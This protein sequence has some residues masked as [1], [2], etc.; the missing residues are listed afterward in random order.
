MTPDE[1]P[2]VGIRP[3]HEGQRAIFTGRDDD[4]TR[5][6]NK[7][8]SARI[9]VLY[10]PSGVGKTSV[11]RALVVPE[12]RESGAYVVY[13]DSWATDDWMAPLRRSL[14]KS[15]E[16]A[17]GVVAEDA[18]LASTIDGA[19]PG[20]SVVLI[21]DQLEFLLLR[22]P[23][24]VDT[25]RAELAAI[26]ACESD[27]RILLSLR[28]EYLAALDPF[29]TT[30]LSILQSTMR[31]QALDG[32]AAERALIEP[33]E[34]FGRSIDPDLVKRIRSDLEK[35]D[36]SRS[37]R[38]SIELTTLQVIGKVLWDDALESKAMRLTLDAYERL[39][40]RDG[41]CNKFI[42]SA[43]GSLSIIDRLQAAM[44]LE[45]LA[46]PD[47]LKMTFEK[48]RLRKHAKVSRRRLERILSS[49]ESNFVVR[50]RRT[51]HHTY[52]ELQ[53]DALGKML[54]A[55]IS[56]RARAVRILRP[57]LSVLA[58]SGLVLLSVAIAY[59]AS[60]RADYAQNVAR[61]L[62]V[63]EDINADQI[64]TRSKVDEAISWVLASKGGDHAERLLR[65]LEKRA[66]RVP[67][68][69]WLT[70]GVQANEP[71]ARRPS[72]LTLSLNP[73]RRLSEDRLV[74]EWRKQSGDL[75]RS[76]GVPLPEDLQVQWH[77]LSSDVAI[78]SFGP[79]EG[80]SFSNSG[81]T[82][83][84]LPAGI[85][86]GAARL[87]AS[88]DAAALALSERLAEL[89]H[90]QVFD[91]T[92]LPPWAVPVA[93][94]TG[95]LDSQE[96]LVVEAL[97]DQI[98]RAPEMALTPLAVDRLLDEAG[99]IDPHLERAVRRW[100][101]DP[102]TLQQALVKRHAS[103]AS[104][105]VSPACIPQ[106]L[107][108]RLDVDLH[109]ILAEAVGDRV[110][111]PPS[112]GS[113]P[114][115]RSETEAEDLLRVFGVTPAIEQSS[116]EP[117]RI[118][119]EAPR[120]GLV[121]HLDESSAGHV[122]EA[123][124]AAFFRL[125]GQVG[126]S[127][128]VNPQQDIAGG[129]TV[130][131]RMRP[132]RLLQFPDAPPARLRSLL[133]K[134]LAEFLVEG[135]I[136]PI[137]SFADGFLAQSTEETRS[138]MEE[139]FS[140]AFLY[141]LHSELQKRWLQ[142]EGREAHDL[143]EVI[144]ALT[145]CDAYIRQ[146][147]T[148]TQTFL[149]R[150]VDCVEGVISASLSEDERAE[151][152]SSIARKKVA[153]GIDHLGWWRFEEASEVFSEAVAADSATAYS[154]FARS[155]SG[156][157]PLFVRAQLGIQCQAY[158]R[159]ATAIFRDERRSWRDRANLRE[160]YIRW[161][162][163]HSPPA[164][165]EETESKGVQPYEPEEI[166]LLAILRRQ[167]PTALDMGQETFREV[168]KSFLRVSDPDHVFHLAV[169]SLVADSS[170]PDEGSGRI[171]RDLFLRLFALESQEADRGVRRITD[172]IEE[173]PADRRSYCLR[174]MSK[175]VRGT[176]EDI[177]SRVA[178][179]LIRTRE[180]QMAKAALGLLG[181]TTAR[182]NGGV[183]RLRDQRPLRAEAHK[184]LAEAGYT[185]E[186]AKAADLYRTLIDEWDG[187]APAWLIRSHVE[188]LLLASAPSDALAELDRYARD[189]APERLD[190]GLHILR[191]AIR[192]SEGAQISR[193]SSTDRLP[194]DQSSEFMALFL[195]AASPL[196]ANRD[197]ELLVNY[198]EVMPLRR[199]QEARLILASSR[200]GGGTRSSADYL[201]GRRRWG[202]GNRHSDSGEGLPATIWARALEQAAAADP[203]DSEAV[204]REL[205]SAA[206]AAIA[207]AE[208]SFSLG[209]VENL[210]T[211]D[212]RCQ[213]WFYQG[214]LSP[215]GRDRMIYFRKAVSTNALSSPEYFAARRFLGDLERERTRTAELGRL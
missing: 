142:T 69:L 211:S 1:H 59:W 210:S 152:D 44:V 54:E 127:Y 7:I 193:S 87:R 136:L 105:L 16:G 64:D 110:A 114:P 6:S 177:E 39:G 17:P 129:G 42:R 131:F 122:G 158:L 134:S 143:V 60:Q 67:A 164:R 130:S 50:R 48:E 93:A 86:W 33:I 83:F 89:G 173:C 84:Q 198:D 36:R 92:T 37:N 187:V 167:N 74:R 99:V 91:K 2:F 202:V 174:E 201:P 101:Q 135:P 23:A 206:A 160:S 81:E 170:N 138:W 20:R 149:R 11:L 199:D 21:L 213:M 165:R 151:D 192:F 186:A 172:A 188:S 153:K 68:D 117:V 196:S 75:E 97:L 145:F 189:A 147:M 82:R 179:L 55:W 169:W 128:S 162:L 40:G 146:D 104:G 18:D 118:N 141:H 76:L 61:R 109:A 111:H 102:L 116:F 62:E 45:C 204:G 190:P 214:L 4:A 8:Y 94:A 32:D 113:K 3:Y 28:E 183:P 15:L 72:Q 115:S 215:D 56:R 5:I 178:D 79:G 126:F 58:A 163:L 209:Q 30:I 38:A 123:L 103:R 194:T 156:Q 144:P 80:P 181:S 10:A 47:G 52:Y 57:T 66:G 140:L 200:A 182:E 150:A 132:G 96:A 121:S 212:I 95:S 191:D 148:G 195:S 125:T 98:C 63:L 119:I 24:E 31:L 53:H 29:K 65:D 208:E 35:I 12:L 159:P 22:E 171:T 88:N 9:S 106:S 197:G 41:I 100:I 78:V 133:E 49:L 175:I 207:A 137:D 77:T 71:L 14:R 27:V 184:V 155:F 43:T 180:T 176:G 25:F 90:A 124:E 108:P 73:Y 166:C 203:G 46:P 13:H 70:H 161:S 112:L 157:R 107:F 154:E 19:R 51:R 185:D 139:R 34:H 26:L 85:R 168:A 205:E 120:A